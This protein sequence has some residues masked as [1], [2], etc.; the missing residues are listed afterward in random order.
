M[1]GHPA[2]RSLFSNPPGDVAEA[3]RHSPQGWQTASLQ[4]ARDLSVE[5]GSI[6]STARPEGLGLGG[7]GRSPLLPTCLTSAPLPCEQCP[8]QELPVT[9][10]VFL[11]AEILQPRGIWRL[12][13][14]N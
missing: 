4:E 3:E 6:P 1:G 7:Q 2:S 10:A 11:S 8:H 9:G 12:E 14:F 13:C 5:L